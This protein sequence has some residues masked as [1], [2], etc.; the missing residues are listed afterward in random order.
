MNN[1]QINLLLAVVGLLRK[2]YLY[3]NNSF[4]VK[5]ICLLRMTICA[6]QDCIKLIPPG[7]SI[8]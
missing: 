7:K 8:H 2:L 1:L 4:L 5:I 3:I 6:V